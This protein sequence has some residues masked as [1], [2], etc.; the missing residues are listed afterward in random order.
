VATKCS[1]AFPVRQRFRLTPAGAE[2]LLFVL[3]R[4]KPDQ[5]SIQR[6]VAGAARRAG[7]TK[8]CSPHVLRHYLPFLTMSGSAGGPHGVMGTWQ[9]AVDLSRDILPG[10]L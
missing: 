7:I 5:H 10:A 8:P 3:D 2:E 9:A 4:E 6:A 1:V